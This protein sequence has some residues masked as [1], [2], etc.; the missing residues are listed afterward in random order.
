MIKTVS[1]DVDFVKKLNNSKFTGFVHS[2][3][4]RTFNIKCS[5]NNE[6]YTIACRNVD[7]GPNTLIIDVD[8]I[9]P[10]EIAVNDQVFT[11]KNILHI[12][13]KLA[14]SFENVN[15]WIS[16]VPGYPSNEEIL[17]QNLKKLKKF[18]DI[19]GKS[20]G[21]KKHELPNSLFEAKMSNMLE[22]RT[23][24]LLD[25]LAED[26]M[27]SAFE[28][29]ISIIGLGPGLTPSGDDFLV[30]LFTSFSML[31]SPFYGRRSFCEDVVSKAKTLT[32]DISWMALQKAST[33][34]VRESIIL[35]LNALLDENEADLF[36]S[37]NKVLNIGSS[38]GTD[39]ALGL[40]GGLEANIKAGGK[41]YVSTSID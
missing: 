31:N 36:L 30:G 18:I 35:L 4:N 24:L 19:H 2:T 7:N 10:M 41:L 17:N 21:I 20:G 28:H 23:N 9:R 38:S 32:N 27:S 34:K 22:Q 40:V 1:A 39:I 15:Q 26:R 33:G 29:A 5:Q 12:G 16:V 6:L 3:F 14:I 13:N 25:E 37:L 11:K 8:N